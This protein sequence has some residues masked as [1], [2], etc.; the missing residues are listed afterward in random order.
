MFI[1]NHNTRVS[2]ISFLHRIRPDYHSAGRV[3]PAGLPNIL[4]LG[5]AHLEA[6]LA[7]PGAPNQRQPAPIVTTGSDPTRTPGELWSSTTRD[8]WAP[9]TF[10]PTPNIRPTIRAFQQ[11]LRTPAPP[12]L[13]GSD[14]LIAPRHNKCLDHDYTCKLRHPGRRYRRTETP[15]PRWCLVRNLSPSRSKR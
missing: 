7:G 8:P 12:G 13:L 6:C 4:R 15:A 10:R 1:P 2:N 14:L 11:R 9:T 5:V 3:W